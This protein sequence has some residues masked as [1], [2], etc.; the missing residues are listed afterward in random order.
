VRFGEQREKATTQRREEGS[1]ETS[2]KRF[3]PFQGDLTEK[4]LPSF[5]LVEDMSLL[6]KKL[7]RNTRKSKLDFWIRPI[8]LFSVCYSARR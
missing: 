8:P 1:K 5:F 7:M 2:F 6:R 3:P 4:T